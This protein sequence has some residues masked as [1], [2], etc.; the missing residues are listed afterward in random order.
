MFSLL[1]EISLRHWAKSPFRSALVAFGIALGVALYLATETAS[2]SMFA[3]FEDFVARVSGRADLTIEAPGLGVPAERVADV[4]EVPG[5]E[6]AA[7]TIEM[8]VQAVDFG[9]SILLFG[10]DFFAN[11]HFLPIEAR[12]G[13]QQV[14]KDPLAFANDPTAILVSE[15]F[16][17]RHGL[18]T[19]GTLRLL[20]ANGPQAF[21]VKGVLSDSGPAAAFDGQVAVMFI[22]ALQ[23]AFARGT[24]VDRIDVAVKKGQ[25]VDTVRAALAELLGPGATVDKPERMGVRLR[26]LV[27]PL[28]AGLALSGFLALLVGG[29]LVYNAVGVAV[30]QRRREIGVLRS[31]GVTQSGARALFALEAAILAVPGIALGILL[32]RVLSRYATAMTVDAMNRLYVSVGHVDPEITPKLAIQAT[33]AGLTASVL[34]AWI[35]ARRGAAVDPA[36]VLRGSAGVEMTRVPAFRL[37]LGGIALLIL[38]RSPVMPHGQVYGA[39]AMALAMAGAALLTPALIVVLCRISGK[40]VDRLFGISPRLGLDYI[41][42]SLGRSTVNVLAL[43]VA[44][45]MSVCVGGWLT[46]L[47]RSIVSWADEMG[48]ADLSVTRGS[49]ILDRRHVV[50]AASAADAVAAVPGVQSV[51]RFRMIDENVGD[52]SIRLVATDTETFMVEAAKVGKTWKLLRG[53]PLRR[54]ELAEGPEILLSEGAAKRLGK[55]LGD[56]V[57]FHSPKGDVMFVVRGVMVD[58]SSETGTCII[59]RRHLLSHWGDE[60]V[61]GISVYVASPGD[62]DAVAERIRKSL[63]G[64]SSVFVTKTSSVRSQLI[65]SLHQTF[66]YSRSV[67]FVTLLIALLGVVGTMIAAVIDRSREIG[68]LRAIGA[69]SRQVALIIVVEAGFLGVC[70]ALA[71]TALGVFLCE[72]FLRTVLVASAGWHVDF[73]FPWEPAGRITSLVVVM[74]AIAGGIPAWRAARANIPASVVCE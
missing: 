70:A 55:D 14:V 46:S 37:A 19:G 51:Q 62:A 2:S 71:G 53:S 42:R 5:V 27:R 54:D 60:S 29:F 9:E 67:E 21:T 66:A 47:E 8:P 32:G 72:L 73:S 39:I 33:I 57:T 31:L 11:D 61:D 20:T 50:F 12:Q 6:A 59:D 65:D 49:P 40:V 58:Y 68:M 35:P 45:S 36:I 22:D 13:E 15:R 52:V 17:N 18:K 25:D 3:A 56:S 38:A 28:H 23:V 41:E 1:R 7:P 30:A 44:V 64:D 48:I 43:M 4:S 69:S 63:G 26:S 24:Y 10:V 16:A 74:S 34:A